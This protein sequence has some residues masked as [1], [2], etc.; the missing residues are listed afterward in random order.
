MG[1]E[2]QI[3][4]FDV[5][6]IGPIDVNGLPTATKF[7]LANAEYYFDVAGPL[8]AL[9][10]FDAGQAYA[11]GA[12]LSARGFKTSTGVEM[13]FIMPVLNV[14]FRLIYAYNPSR[15][16]FHPKSGFKFAVG[17]TF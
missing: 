11:E 13:R 3:R 4:G 6:T 10:F 5:R 9:I 7:A 12:K 16:E 15:E 8:R 17:A 1:G 14:P 2:T